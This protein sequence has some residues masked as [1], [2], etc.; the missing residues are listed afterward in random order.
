MIDVPPYGLKTIQEILPHRHPF[1]FIDKVAAITLGNDIVAEKTF[2]ADEW[3]F[4]GHF[5]GRPIIPGV[6]IS[7]ALAQASGLLI[8]LTAEAKHLE[9][10]DCYL[11][12]LNLKF[13]ATAEPGET[14]QLT[15][16]LKKSYAKMYLFDVMAQV[17]AR[18]I[19]DGTLILASD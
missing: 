4:S 10:S 12:K 14:L 11:A 8:G 17:A 19:A 18:S 9:K 16:A 6:I 15:S 2:A 1:L 7:E 5:P 3:F 13:V